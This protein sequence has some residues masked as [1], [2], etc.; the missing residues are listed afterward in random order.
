MEN[1][2]FDTLFNS[3]KNHF[4]TEEPDKNHDKRFLA[5]LNNQN[6]QQTIKLNK[7]GLWRPLLGIAASIVLIIA[8]LVGNKE[9]VHA[10]GLA[11]VSPEMAETQGFFESTI[12]TELKKLETYANGDTSILIK[13]A[14]NQMNRLETEYELLKKDLTQSGNDQRVIYAMITNFQNRIDI[15][16]NTLKQIERVK[17]LNNFK[18]ENNNTI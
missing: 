14:L 15:L 9:N 12:S 10:T 1:D 8:L 3:L 13:D 2:S 6:N 5:K 11:S 16:Q 18:N 7:S 17:Q 4:D